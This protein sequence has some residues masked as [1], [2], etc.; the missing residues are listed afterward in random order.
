VSPT[1]I[2]FSYLLGIVFAVG[3]ILFMVFLADNRFLFG[4]PYLVIGLLLIGGVRGVQRR[5][6]AR[7][8]DP[9]A[10]PPRGGH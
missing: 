4:V 10:G 3:G 8:A 6:A 1:G 2:L 5:R 9:D 7:E